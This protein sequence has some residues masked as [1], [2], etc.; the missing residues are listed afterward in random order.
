MKAYVYM[1]QCG[2]LDKCQAWL[3]S[4]NYKI[5]WSDENGPDA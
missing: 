2:D 1:I 3:E 4:M 5:K